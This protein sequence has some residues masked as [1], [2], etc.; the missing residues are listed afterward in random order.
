MPPPIFILTLSLLLHHPPT[1]DP[2]PSTSPHLF[3]PVPSVHLPLMTNLFSALS[4]IHT[5]FLGPSLLP[6]FFWSVDCSS[7]VIL[8]FMANV[9]L[10][11]RELRSG[12]ERRWGGGCR[13][14]GISVGVL[15]RN[16]SPMPMSSRQYSTF[17]FI[18]FVCQI[19]C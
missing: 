11:V 16:L 14:I 2:H 4:E 1:P 18:R 17:F 7:I 13:G 9:Q 19:S 10:Y 15:F 5:S 3:H 12:W 6:I 8:H